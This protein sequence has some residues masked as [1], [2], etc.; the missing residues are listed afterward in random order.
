MRD[1][2]SKWIVKLS[3]KLKN[4]SAHRESRNL[5]CLTHAIRTHTQT[6]R[7]QLHEQTRHTY[8]YKLIQFYSGWFDDCYK[9][10]L[11]FRISQ[12]VQFVCQLWTES[13]DAQLIGITFVCTGFMLNF[14]IDFRPYIVQL[15]PLVPCT[16]TL[17]AQ[18]FLIAFDRVQFTFQLDI[19]IVLCEFG[20]QACVAHR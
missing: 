16:L 2:K 19:D 18:H 9:W 11:L 13:I 3:P 7:Q 14:Q 12:R 1:S 10:H 17:I 20:M 15:I 5:V 6:Y 4:W 8:K